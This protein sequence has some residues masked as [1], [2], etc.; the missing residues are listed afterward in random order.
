VTKEDDTDP[1]GNFDFGDADENAKYLARFESGEFL[2]A[3]IRVEASYLG[4]KGSDSLGACHMK[5]SD[6]EGETDDTIDSHGM[7]ENAIKQLTDELD[8]LRAALT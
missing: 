5:A 1:A 7:I 8:L 2:V 6:I 3:W 4:V